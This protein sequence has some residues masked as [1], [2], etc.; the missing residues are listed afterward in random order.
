VGEEIA[1]PGVAGHRRVQALLGRAIQRGRL[2]HAIV[3]VGPSG[4]GKT[5]LA[6]GLGC[7][8]ACTERPGVGC[9]TC[10]TC[11][12]ILADRH[13]D[14]VTVRSS[15]KGNLLRVEQAEELA[16]Q[17]QQAPFEAARHVIVID[18]AERLHEAAANKLLKAIEEP[19][20]N[21]HWVL[22]TANE[23]ELLPTILSRCLVLVLDRVDDAAV[24]QVLERDACARGEALD[25]QRRG[26]AVRLAQGCPGVALTLVED[27]AL[28]DA[29]ALTAAAIEATLAGPEAIFAG[30]KSRLWSAFQDAVQAIP[31]AE[32]QPPD[33]VIVVKGKGPRGKKS[34]ARAGRPAAAE[35]SSRSDLTPA[36]Q[37]AAAGRLADLW[38]LH[39]RE[40]LRGGAGLPGLPDLAGVAPDRL[41]RHI[42]R[43]QAFQDAL[44]RNPNVRLALEATLL[45]LTE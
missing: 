45:E 12:R 32:E 9:G 24:D 29:R 43:V 34:R 15:G 2:H 17:S 30:E 44:A 4:V 7:A 13:T 41:V 5:T 14:F 19:R 16:L 1:F 8:L 40:R 11:T 26:I 25:V 31:D 22:V 35:P 38:L 28:A 23:R 36:R 6:R 10:P 3:L 37:R 39:L 27:H 20:P 42:A 18:G 21:V 33:P